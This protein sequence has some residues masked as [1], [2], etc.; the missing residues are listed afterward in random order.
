MNV[1]LYRVGRNLNRAYRTCEA[2]GVRDLLLWEC[3]GD[4]KGNLFA[5]KDRVE[6]REVD[7][8]PGRV[9]ALETCYEQPVREADWR[10]VDTLLIGGESHEIPKPRTGDY[11]QRLTIPQQGKVSGLTVEAALAVALY[12][13]RRS[14]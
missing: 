1:C 4:L 10:W 14:Q 12:E 2:F 7:E 3:H 6:M 8:P 5:A 9:A 13:W 11:M